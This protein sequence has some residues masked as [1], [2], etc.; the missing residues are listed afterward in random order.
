MST[1]GPVISTAAS[2]ASVYYPAYVL[3]YS[4]SG[5]ALF[6]LVA[7]FVFRLVYSYIPGLPSLYSTSVSPMINDVEFI[8]SFLPAILVFYKF[9]VMGGLTFIAMSIIP[10]LIIGAALLGYL[11]GHGSIVAAPRRA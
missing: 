3:S 11:A 7:M 9:G 5:T 1:L 2:T 6:H 4:P 8:A 10:G